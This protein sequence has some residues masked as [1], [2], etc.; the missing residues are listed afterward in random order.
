MR[1]L[2]LYDIDGTLLST[3]GAGRSA[4][5]EAFEALHG[6]RGAFTEVHFGGRTDPGIVSQAF[7]LAGLFQAEGD[8]EALIE[9]YLP[10]LQRRLDA[11]RPDLKPGVLELLDATAE[12]GINALLTG[13]M[14]AGAQRKLSAVGLWERFEL[15]AYG[16]DS[17]RREDL[18]PVA[19]QRAR[20]AGL[21]FDQTLVLGDTVHDVACARAG[22][23]IAVA[24]CTGWGE[25]ADL[26]AC[27]PDLLLEDLESGGQALLDL[28]RE[29]GARG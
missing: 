18:V 28:V 23:A 2:F 13:N 24:V 12:L 9:D 17:P 6:V 5:D 19:E 26:R 4:L 7:E 11:R 29:R 15:G 10:R 25:A 22:G 8:F 21:R 3:G 16:D 20:R 14:E 27:E 1:T